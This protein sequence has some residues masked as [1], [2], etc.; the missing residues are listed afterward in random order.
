MVTL[1]LSAAWRTAK[2]CC[3]R[4][5][6]IACASNS[7]D[8]NTRRRRK[9]TGD[10]AWE[11]REKSRGFLCLFIWF[12]W[13]LDRF[14]YRV[15]NVMFFF[16]TNTFLFS[17]TKCFVCVCCSAARMGP[18]RYVVHQECSSGIS[19]SSVDETCCAYGKT[20]NKP[21]IWGWF[22]APIYGCFCALFT[23]GF[24]TVVN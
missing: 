4:R 10:K 6:R 17:L 20:T 19:S 14:Y 2:W 3:A 11:H 12:V 5:R 15:N 21:T 23:S 8:R 24:T 13:F 16:C 22:I 7:W 1:R 9:T 18:S